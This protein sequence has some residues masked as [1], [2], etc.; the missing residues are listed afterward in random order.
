MFNTIL[1]HNFSFQLHNKFNTNIIHHPHLVNNHTLNYQPNQ[2][3]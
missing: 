2:Y 3:Y 1:G